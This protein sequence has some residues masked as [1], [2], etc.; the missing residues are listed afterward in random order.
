MSFSDTLKKRLHSSYQSTS[1]ADVF[2][3]PLLSEAKLYRRVSAYFSSAGIELY[4]HGLQELFENNGYAK[5]IISTNIS[6]DDFKK[7]Q[8]GY[9]VR[10]QIQQLSQEIRTKIL[11][12]ETQ[13]ELGNLAFMIAQGRAEVKFAMLSNRRDLFHDKFGIISDDDDTVVFNGSVNE[14]EAGLE[15]NYESISVDFSWDESLH[16][17]QRIKEY[18][19]R[20][21]RLWNNEESGVIVKEATDTVYEQLAVFQDQSTINSVSILEN[22]DAITEPN[23]E[24]V[25]FRLNNKNQV[26]REDYSRI[27]IVSNDRKLAYDRSD[28]SEYF[29]MDNKT[30]KTGVSYR[31]IQNIIDVT[32]DRCD[33]KSI[34]VQI[35]KSVKEFLTRNKYA[36][37][38]YQILGT[39]LKD[40]GKEFE[41][42]KKEDFD[43]FSKTVQAEVV[44]PLK[45][46]HM[47]AAYYEYSMARAANFS[48]PGAGK[49][50]MIL[51]VFAYL[52]SDKIRCSGEFINKILVI[53]PINAFDSWKSEF[54]KVFGNKKE[55]RCVDSQT[56]SDFSYEVNLGW[57]TSN[58]ILVNY[59]SLQSYIGVLEKLIDSKTMLVFD[60]VHRIKNPNGQRA[61][62]ALQLVSVPK[63]KF[64]MTGTPIPNSYMDI[65][66]F[67]HILY[68]NEYRSF[69]GWDIDIL[70]N[71]SMNKI[72]EIQK[73][74][75]PFFWRVNKKDLGVPPANKDDVRIVN[76]SEQQ[77]NLAESIYYHEKSS[78]ARLIRLIQASTNPSLLTQAI[79]YAQMGFD[80]E[81]DDSDIGEKSFN[82]HL[83]EESK[84]VVTNAKSYEEYNLQSMTS[85]KFEAGVKLVEQLV[86]QHKK[87][88]VWAIFVDTMKKIRERLIREKINASLIYGGTPVENRSS[89]LEDFKNGNV[90]VMISNPQTLG[91]SVS[92]HE[93][94][95]DAIYFEYNFNLTYMLQSR[96]RIHRLGLP[97][98]QYT[99]YYYLET[100]EEDSTSGRPGFIDQKIYKR[101]KE[102]ESTMS[103]VIDKDSLAIEYSNDEIKDAIKII[104]AE[105]DRIVNNRNDGNE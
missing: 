63:F 67:L 87:V 70:K 99:Q 92:L 35:T 2:Y 72:D 34:P 104:D 33:R 93:H 23:F 86:S 21:E 64:V 32:K 69:F 5:F 75:F 84:P 38:Q 13:S 39:L 95:H 28:L 51:G 57:E 98:N 26:V 1:L 46:L 68:G 37:A 56:S 12:R 97:D 44:R 76:P 74:L 65:Y 41:H 27:K 10:R 45:E 25:Y 96:D 40:N 47:R 62:S 31:E 42:F 43:N 79:S 49:T 88:I 89:M 6:Q 7:I 14:T 53:S 36:I 101:L 102:K 94:V 90:S 59:E 80:S 18:D 91:E 77:L 9:H 50:A 105:R 71:P 17:K 3:K 85:P 100:R 30:I 83:H 48:V 78:L 15:K 24:G 82:E 22:A 66:N 4:S 103:E 11:N 16:V 29:E 81:D 52:N 73:K 60:E 20:F 61:K 54:K 55:L 19:A 8:E 58:L